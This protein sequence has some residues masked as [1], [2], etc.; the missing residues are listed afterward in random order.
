MMEQEDKR[1]QLKTYARYSGMAAEMFGLLI[2]MVIIGKKLDA[3]MENQKAYMTAL[4]VFVG[5]AGYLYKLYLEL[6][7]P[8]P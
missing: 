5:S 1:K 8:K 7:K 3:W 6:T 2:V 4:L